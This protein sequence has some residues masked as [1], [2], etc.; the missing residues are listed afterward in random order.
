M[1]AKKKEPAIELDNSSNIL[2]TPCGEINTDVLVNIL[3][4]AHFEGI[5][6]TKLIVITGDKRS[7]GFDSTNP[8]Y[9]EYQ[10]AVS[11]NRL[12]Q[13]YKENMGEPFAPRTVEE[14][15]QMSR[16]DKYSK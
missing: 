1:P 12:Y 14:M 7:K 16:Y 4:E 11:L 10:K 3:E 15:K 8:C 6:K 13:M 9:E 5:E 2:I